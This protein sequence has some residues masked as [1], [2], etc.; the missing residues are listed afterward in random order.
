M[1]MGLKIEKPIKYLGVRSHQLDL[2]VNCK[3]RLNNII[4]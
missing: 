2:D 1:L 4:C 3:N